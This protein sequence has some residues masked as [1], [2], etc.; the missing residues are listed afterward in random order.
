MGQ[1]VRH[2]AADLGAVQHV[3]QAGRRRH[4]GILGITARRKGVRLVVRDDG[5][6][7]Q[8]H[9]GIGR[10]LFYVRHIGPHDGI[11]VALVHHLGLVHF[12]HDLVGIPVAEQVHPCGQ[13]KGDGHATR[14]ADHE[15]DAHE[16]GCHRGQKNEGLEMVHV[17]CDV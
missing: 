14:A 3:E 9:A 15:A 8:R 17:T 12:Q 5:D 11:G 13:H 2:Y 4:G 1:F 16:Q 7:G 10:H 6:L